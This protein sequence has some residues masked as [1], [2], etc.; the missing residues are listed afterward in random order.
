M[1]R[2]PGISLLVPTQNAAHTL[3]ACIRSFVDYADEIVCVDNGSTDGSIEIAR[4]LEAEI[5]KLRFFDAPHLRDLY[6]NR[7]YALERS[8]YDWITRID[9]DYVA[10]TD[11]PRDI[12]RLRERVLAT[13]R[14]VWPVSFEIT[15]VNLYHRLDRTGALACDRPTAGAGRYVTEPITR[16][17]SRIVQ[18]FPGM[19]FIRR[20]RWE[21]V[22]CQP[23][24]HHVRLEEP[25]WF[26]CELKDPVDYLMRSERTNWRELGDFARYPDLA[27]F[28]RERIVERYGTD[29]LAH[30]A[31]LYLRDH[32]LPYLEP[33]DEE[34]YYP[35]P[36]GVLRL[37]EA[38]S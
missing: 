25:H 15:Q 5:P 22:R 9:S 37:H 34:R 29:D 7:Q 20:G 27:T 14:S 3:E 28:L 16:L 21:G 19:R 10:Y 23:F 1:K 17:G 26:H 31:D 38:L 36:T 2:R 8:H 4:A 30:A 6:E 35:Y 24:L 32:V 12:R 18:Y 13:R 33:Y 11:G